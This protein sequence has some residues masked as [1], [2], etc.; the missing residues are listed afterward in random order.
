MIF[1]ITFL[2]S[3]H[4]TYTGTKFDTRRAFNLKHNG[5]PIFQSAFLGN[6]SSTVNL[7]NN[8]INIPDHFFVT[9]E[10]LVYSYEN[11]LVESTNAIGIVTQ[12]VAGVSTDKLPTEVFAVKLSNSSVGLLQPSAVA[13]GNNSR[14]T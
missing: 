12:S 7:T 9:G 8:S 13:T 14:Y 1:K 11:S 3:N 10:K 5:L 4:G 6:D 2:F